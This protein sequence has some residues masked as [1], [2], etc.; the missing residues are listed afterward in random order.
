M[1]TIFGSLYVVLLM[2]AS[3]LFCLGQENYKH[4]NL[5]GLGQVL[6]S[7][8]VKLGTIK[9]GVI[10]NAAGEKVGKIEKQ[11]LFDYKGHK[12]GKI[13]K[14]GTFYDE[15]GVVVFTIDPNSKGEKCKIVD[16]KGN[17]IATVHESYKNQACA[18]HCLYKKMPPH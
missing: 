1:K 4:P 5:N 13:G 8:G 11:E 3:T 16:P 14:D 15:K 12:L 9:E 7:T 18:I 10:Y 2:I 6:D 17:V